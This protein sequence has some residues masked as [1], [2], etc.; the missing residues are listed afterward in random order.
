M[1]ADSPRNAVSRAQRQFWR[2]IPRGACV[3]IFSS[4]RIFLFRRRGR[5]RECLCFLLGFS[6]LTI[7]VNSSGSICLSSCIA[8]PH[9]PILL[10]HELELIQLGP[11]WTI[12]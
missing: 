5:S 1:I 6:Q 8:N 10:R 4:G 7:N 9:F 2:T 3:C 12:G 11:V